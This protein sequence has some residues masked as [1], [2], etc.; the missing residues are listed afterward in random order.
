MNIR[1]ML[2]IMVVAVGCAVAMP[3]NA[4]AATIT[5]IMITDGNVTQTQNGVTYSVRKDYNHPYVEYTSAYGDRYDRQLVVEVTITNHTGKAFNYTAY[6]TAADANG[7]QLVNANALAA[8][9]F[10]TIQNG[11][12]VTLQSIFLLTKAND[13]TTFTLGYQHM[14]YSS[15]YIADMNLYANGLLS[16]ADLASRYPQTP[17]TLTVNYPMQHP[18]VG[19]ANRR[20]A[21]RG[22]VSSGTTSSK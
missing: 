12:S 1:E 9:T 22:S 4:E 8:G 3:Q 2:G 6:M 13:V 15:A 20:S 14:D 10:G 7:Q 19:G 17:V 5:P 16:A 21:I 11:A 18:G